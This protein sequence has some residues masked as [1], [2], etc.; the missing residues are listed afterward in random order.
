MLGK[1]KIGGSTVKPFRIGASSQLS[2]DWCIVDPVAAG[3]MLSGSK[4]MKKTLEL[5]STVLKGA[6]QVSFK[7]SLIGIQKR[8]PLSPKP[9]S[10]NPKWVVVKI[11]FPFWI[12]IIV[13]HLIFRVTK[14]GP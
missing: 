9:S 13:R 5:W 2:H 6:E 14:R 1:V 3:L 12:P 11:M 10:L 7:E 4:L 8:A